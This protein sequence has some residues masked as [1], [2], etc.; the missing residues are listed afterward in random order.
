MTTRGH[1]L[2]GALTLLAVLLFAGRWTSQFLADQWWAATVSPAVG[3][4]LTRRALVGLALD[5]AGVLLATAWFLGNVRLA[6]RA[7]G[8]LGPRERGGNPVVRRALQQ[9]GA[10][11]IAMA[12]AVLLGLL[13]GSGLSAWTDSVT[14]AWTGVRYGVTEPAL[15][16]DAGVFVAWLPLGLGLQA[17]GTVLVL[18][19]LGLVALLLIM[20]GAVRIGRGRLA[21]TDQARRHLGLLLLLLA[22]VIGTSQVLEPYQLAAGIPVTLTVGVVRLHRSVSMVLV[23]MSLAVALLSYTWSRRPVHSLV[24]GAWLALSA[25][26]VSSNYLLPTDQPDPRDE[27]HASIR[28]RAEAIGYGLE[29]LRRPLEGGEDWQFSL[30]DPAMLALA[31]GMDST[32]A[33]PGRV[34]WGDD[35]DSRPAWGIVGT[36]WE[37]IQRL[38]VVAD[39]SVTDH[40]RPVSLGYP[41]AVPDTNL[42]RN[43]GLSAQVVRPGAPAVVIGPDAGVPLGRFP[44]RLALAWALQDGGLIA[45]EP[46]QRVDWYLDPT[47]R[48]SHAVPFAVW[49]GA[50]PWIDGDRLHWIVDGYLVADA[51]PGTRRVPWMGR[52]TALVRAGF[53]GVVDATTGATTVFLRPGADSLAHAWA[54][55]ADDV[56]QPASGM[57]PAL[58]ARLAYPEALLP[59][60]AALLADPLDGGT[61]RAAAT[62]PAPRGPLPG[63]GPGAYV[64]PLLDGG[65][66]RLRALLQGRYRNGM[67]ELVLVQP[68]SLGAPEAPDVLSRRWQRFPLVQEIADSVVASGG[69]LRAGRVRYIATG[70]GLLAYQPFWAVSGEGRVALAAVAAARGDRLAVGRS[71]PD[72]LRGLATGTITRSSLEGDET[73]LEMARRLIAEAD[74]AL[75]EGD[76]AAFGRLFGQ[77]R[78]VLEGRPAPPQEPR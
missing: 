16:L 45:T 30:W 57:P 10:R 19:A 18:T 47:T 21:I 71:A 56:I 12:S 50:Y 70:Q 35:A 55:S 72:A 74:S 60:Q 38:V 26:L 66:L 49:R 5:A 76:L 58:R 63:G 4:L 11:Q 59:L 36:G 41:P 37:N 69:A 3:L 62:P 33:V 52:L 68:D 32:I 24:A 48:L 6:W 8:E 25:A 78:T 44:R 1:R 43:P 40:G 64:V 53:V 77:L 54:R 9:P 20:T 75:R 14:L 7:I 28:H 73:T 46:S 27:E 65:N 29:P 13:V 31:A 17:L 2:A 39:D 23:G 22:L 34:A 51:F 61:V 67:D 42:R 15:G